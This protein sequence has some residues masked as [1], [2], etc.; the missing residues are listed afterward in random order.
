MTQRKRIT[1]QF[2]QAVNADSLMRFIIPGLLLIGVLWGSW[3]AFMGDWLE[4]GFAVAGV[5]MLLA[6]TAFQP[7]QKHILGQSFNR[8]HALYVALSWLYAST[9]L[10]LFRLLQTSPFT[11]KA[12]EQTYFIL[13][14]FIAF[15][16]MLLRSLLILTRPF[17]PRFVT[18][19]PLW[20]QILIAINEGVAA[21]ALATFGA[22]VLVHVLQP[23]VFTTRVDVPYVAGVGFVIVCYYVGI[24]LMWLRRWNNWLSQ[25]A[26]WIRLMRLLA[27]LALIVTTMVMVRRFIERA[28]PRS[29]SLIGGSGIDL[30]ILALA[31]VIWLLIF[32]SVIIVYTSR[33]GIR[34]RFL[35]DLLLDRLPKRVG[36]FLRSISDM[37]MLLILGVLATLIPAYMI[38]FGDT[39]GVIGGLR[40]QI[41]QRG[42]ALI[43]TSEQALAVL[44]SLPFYLLI[45]VLLALYGYT[46]S[47]RTLAANQRNELVDRLPI[48]FMIILIITLYLF[49][50]P[51]SQVITE[52][53]LPQLPQDLGRILAFN[54]VIPLLLLYS[55]YFVLIRQPYARGQ[56]RWREQQSQQY[57]TQLN[58]I[59]HRIL[60]LNGEI[61]RLDAQWQREPN[62]QKIET[63]YRYVHLNGQRDDLNMQRL[64][65]VSDRQQ[66][67]ELSETP[68][69]IAIARLPVRVVTIGIPLLLAVQIYQWAILNNG[70]RD[71]VN[72]P[73][74]TIFEFFRTILQ[75]T[76]F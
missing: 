18:G 70:L 55:H 28:D 2:M 10:G 39:G 56:K 60:T 57:T 71:I 4:F 19:I 3:Q 11:G 23:D 9:G 41:L 22:N 46:L 34:Q 29:A 63:L 14:L 6:L 54:V 36:D 8:R 59:D 72:N 37:D 45:V 38:L 52:G 40:Q 62:V 17:Y 42:S 75:Q 69:S 15:A 20:E 21:G 26:V 48:G 73:N 64:Q 53:R 25:S 65:V 49:A 47:R 68:V 1:H 58:S 43:E 32:V 44:F 31:P 50:L 67:A 24:Q 33:R 7:F 16:W 30:A 76:Q 74:I 35:P 12:S 66:L 61:A 13:I 27:P 5:V 51:F